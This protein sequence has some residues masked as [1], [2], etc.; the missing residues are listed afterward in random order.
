MLRPPSRGVEV[1]FGVRENA[2]YIEKKIEGDDGGCEEHGVVYGLRIGILILDCYCCVPGNTIS[3]FSRT[4]G[5]WYL[6]R[7]PHTRRASTVI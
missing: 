4:S 7:K 1:I 6:F 5:T 2:L 3:I